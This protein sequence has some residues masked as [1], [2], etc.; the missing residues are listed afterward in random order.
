MHEALSESA[1]QQRFFLAL[2]AGFA[3]LAVILAA[4]GIY[5]VMSYSVAQRTREM[6]IRIALGATRTRVVKLVVSHGAT[7]AVGFQY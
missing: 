5:G 2:L 6:G 3:V 4:L 7:L 1:I